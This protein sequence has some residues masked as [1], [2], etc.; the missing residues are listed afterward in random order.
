MMNSYRRL[1]GRAPPM[2]ALLQTRQLP[3]PRAHQHDFGRRFSVLSTLK[4]SNSLFINQDGNDEQKQRSVFPRISIVQPLSTHHDAFSTSKPTTESDD[5]DKP[6]NKYSH[7]VSDMKQNMRERAGSF[8]NSARQNLQSFKNDPRS[9]TKAGAKSVTAMLKQYG[10]VFVATY[11]SVY[12]TTLGCLFLGVESGFLDP[13]GLFSS[14]GHATTQGS[15]KGETLSTVQLVTDFMRHHA[16][17]EQYAPYFERNPEV[18]NLAVAWIAV[19]FTEPVRLALSVAVTPKIAQYFGY[20]TKKVVL[21]EVD[22]D[23]DAKQVEDAL[24]DEKDS[25]R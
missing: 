1:A 21:V 5:D 16:W 12:L 18:A 14:L 22:K 10:P 4:R 7:R 11:M 19:K 9:Q 15:A 8:R 17:L 2:S 23:V 25:R 3:L 6:S 24:N 13:A 20:A